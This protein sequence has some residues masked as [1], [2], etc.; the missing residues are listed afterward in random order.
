MAKKVKHPPSWDRRRYKSQVHSC[1]EALADAD[2]KTLIQSVRGLAFVLYEIADSPG[3]IK[4]DD[5]ADIRYVGERLELYMAAL[6][7]RFSAT[8]RFPKST[9][10]QEAVAKKSYKAK[11]RKSNAKD[12]R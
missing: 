2:E 12:R 9:N 10:R 4:K 11:K 8:T 5:E 7:Q 1:L 3:I 6:L